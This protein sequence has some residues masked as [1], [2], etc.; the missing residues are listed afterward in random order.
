MW[1]RGDSLGIPKLT[2]SVIPEPGPKR[3]QHSPTTMFRHRV[4]SQSLVHFDYCT[5]IVSNRHPNPL[6]PPSL[7]D[8]SF[9]KLS[10]LY[11][12]RSSWAEPFFPLILILLRQIPHS[13]ND[14]LS[15]TDVPTFTGL[16]LPQLLSCFFFPQ[17]Y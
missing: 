7:H 5:T 15:Y 10:L 17:N 9:P 8:L 14:S 2:C 16:V 6:R 11:V 13:Q 12:N 1:T 4:P 3:R